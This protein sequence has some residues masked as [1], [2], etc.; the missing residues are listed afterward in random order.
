[1]T[2]KELTWQLNFLATHHLAT[3][4][5]VKEALELHG[6]VLLSIDRTLLFP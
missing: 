1:M 2:E 5:T 4:N 3:H 6:D